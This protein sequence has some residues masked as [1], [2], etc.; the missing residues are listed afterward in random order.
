[1]GLARSGPSLDR[2]AYAYRPEEARFALD[3]MLELNADREWLLSGLIDPERVGAVGHSFGSFTVLSIAGLNEK[4][5][6]PRLRAVLAF[7]GGVFMWQ[8]VD[9]QRLT[10]PVML[11]YGEKEAGQRTR[12]GAR[13]VAA[14]TRRGYENCR[15]PKL[16]LVLKGASHFTFSQG[17]IRGR[18]AAEATGLAAEQ[19]GALNQR[20]LAFLQR[21]VAGDKSADAELLADDPMWVTSEHELE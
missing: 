5:A 14:D 10:I 3:K 9:W 15:P 18:A 17:V 12:F 11:A 6:D 7:S 19:V 13:D 16:L 21:Y 1:M 20:G 8:P 4:Y 2:E